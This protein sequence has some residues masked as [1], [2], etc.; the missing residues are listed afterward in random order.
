MLPGCSLA[1]PLD[2]S[3]ALDFACFLGPGFLPGLGLGLI[4]VLLLPLLELHL[5]RGLG[6]GLELIC[7]S[8]PVSRSD[9]QQLIASLDRLT[10]AV[11]ESGLGVK[12]VLEDWELIEAD[13]QGP[14]FGQVQNHWLEEGPPE[15]PPH[16]L[17]LAKKLTSARGDG[18]DRIRRAFTTGFWARISLNCCVKLAGPEPLA[19]RDTHFLVV[20]AA[21]LP[22]PVRVLKGEERDLLVG[23]DSQALAYGFPSLAE[24]QAFCC[25]AGIEVPALYKWR[26]SAS[27][28]AMR[29]TLA[30]SC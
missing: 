17:L 18:G 2:F 1:S 21:G 15:T 19:L 30:S 12:D 20:R 23:Q 24:V 7:M 26:S 11:R 29:A 5:S 4:P 8:E 10:I 9:I 25:G 16:L 6:E 13:Y 28:S 22:H 27:G 3:L 14:G